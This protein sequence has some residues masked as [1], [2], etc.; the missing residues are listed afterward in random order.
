[1]A[2]E[3]VKEEKTGEKGKFWDKNGSVRGRKWHCGLRPLSRCLFMHVSISR[4]S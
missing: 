2:E 4:P 1:M 3:K